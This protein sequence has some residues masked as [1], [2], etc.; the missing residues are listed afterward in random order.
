M[1][2]ELTKIVDNVRDDLKGTYL[3]NPT[4]VWDLP[5]VAIS[6]RSGGVH[7]LDGIKDNQHV[8]D[9]LATHLAND[10]EAIV[11]GRMV[12]KFSTVLGS[13]GKPVIKEKA[14]MVMGRTL[15]T[16]R[17]YVSITPVMEHRD[18]R[19]DE[20]AEKQNKK[21]DPTLKGADKTSNIVDEESNRV[22]GRLQAKF[23]QEQ[24]M[25]SKKGHQFLCDPI[26]EGV[27]PS[28]A[29]VEEAKAKAQSL[30]A[31][32]IDKAKGI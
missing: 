8:V 23:G 22:V 32:T 21:F 14:I 12:A 4:A 3:Q 7:L 30:N 20:V 31:P 27:F 15:S 13:D 26:I 24:I 25:D 2:A 29:G 6:K 16:G 19:R 9:W 28:K 1:A 18:Y 11:V 17:T 10:V 5:L